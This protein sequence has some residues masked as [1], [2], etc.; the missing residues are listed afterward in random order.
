MANAYATIASGGWRNRPKAITRV[1]FADG[2]VSNWGKP[3]RAKAFRDGVT[4]E[5][6]KILEQNMKSG[7]GV[8]AQIGCPAGGKTGTTDNNTDAWFVGFT[9]NLSTAVWVGFPGQRV[10]M[11]PPTTPISVAGGTYPAT[12]W[13]KYMKVAKKGCGDFTKPKQPFQTKPF[14]GKYQQVQPEPKDQPQG[15]GAD[16]KKDTNKKQNGNGNGNGGGPDNGGAAPQGGAQ[17]AQPQA[18][19]AQPQPAQPTPAQPAQPAPQA[20]AQG[21]A[22]V[23]PAQYVAPG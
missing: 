12:I 10:P 16:K 21:G 2:R 9:P 3:A 23:D 8:G 4:Y 15:G 1:T 17:P 11:N 7:T 13:Q 22:P 19:A 20:P 14:K 18:P 5:A 6:T